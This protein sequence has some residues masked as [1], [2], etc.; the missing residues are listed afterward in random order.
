MELAPMIQAPEKMDPEAKAKWLA[1]LRDPSAKQA[2][3]RLRI[4][5]A[6]CCL[7]HFCDVLDPEGWEG[8][9][10]RTRIGFPP[11]PL[12]SVAKLSESVQ[13]YLAHANDSGYSLLDIADWI[14]KYL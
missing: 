13:N 4:D 1:R 14:E 10:H 8:N 6:M 5:D 9:Y 3:E 12:A 2:R 7:G 11:T